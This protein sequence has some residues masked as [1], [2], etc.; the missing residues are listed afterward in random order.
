[1]FSRH[2]YLLIF[3]QYIFVRLSRILYGAFS[4]NNENENHL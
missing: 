4:L 1:M 3:M 2:P